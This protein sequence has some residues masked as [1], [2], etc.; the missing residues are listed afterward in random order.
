MYTQWTINWFDN[1]D[2]QW[3]DSDETVN[4]ILHYFTSESTNHY[5]ISESTN[6]YFTSE[7]TDHYFTSKD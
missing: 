3:F 4:V 5:F 6:H 1:E 2:D 7:L